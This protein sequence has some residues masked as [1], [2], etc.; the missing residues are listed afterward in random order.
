M[1]SKKKDE[2]INKQT[3]NMDRK[4]FLDVNQKLENLVTPFSGMIMKKNELPGGAR[5][6]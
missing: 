6:E 3:M 5:F 4:Q 1:L 2:E